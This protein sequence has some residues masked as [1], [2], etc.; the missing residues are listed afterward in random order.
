MASKLK[1][2]T[3]YRLLSASVRGGRRARGPR[4]TRIHIPLTHGCDEQAPTAVGLS[5]L[6]PSQP[7]VHVHRKE[8][9]F[10]L[11]GPP[12]RQGD[13]LQGSISTS[14]RAPVNPMEIFDVTVVT[15][16]EM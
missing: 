7:S 9:P 14:H 4:H 8:D 6:V 5:H 11:Q 15:F 10:W 13:E 3:G 16:R 12:F 2:R 1:Q